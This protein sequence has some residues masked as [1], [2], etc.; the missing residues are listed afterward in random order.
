MSLSR[1]QVSVANNALLDNV[2]IAFVVLQQCDA[3]QVF[4][5][6]LTTDQT[7]LIFSFNVDVDE[8]S[9]I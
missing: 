3:C 1:F 6:T 7:A 2:D 4:Q 5:F 8:I 9:S